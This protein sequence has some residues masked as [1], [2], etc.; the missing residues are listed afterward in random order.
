MKT[1]AKLAMAACVVLSGGQQL[2]AD[3][4]VDT[5][6]T[7]QTTNVNFAPSGYKSAFSF[8][9]AAEAVGGERDMLVERTGTSGLVRFDVNNSY[10]GAASFASGPT[11]PG[12]GT[13]TWDGAD[14][15]STT[16]V[17]GLGGVDLTQSGANDK[18]LLRLI[19]DLGATLTIKAY[20]DAAN[21]SM[22]SVAVPTNLSFILTHQGILFSSFTIGGGSGAN[23]ANIGA[24][25]MEVD[26]TGNP[27]T[28]VVFDY[29]ITTALVPEPSSAALWLL[30]ATGLACAR[31]RRA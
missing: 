26:G 17:T 2:R 15:L 31:R 21:F 16:N 5:F 1:V 20:T 11:V 23:F 19:S 3:F 14:G 10:L 6:D 27:G 18:F 22:A 24:I 30:G 12:R 13:L 25:S 9:A 4:F 28:D 8:K 29:V 7:F